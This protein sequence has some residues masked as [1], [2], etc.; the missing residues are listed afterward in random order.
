[1]TEIAKLAESLSPTPARLLR[2]LASRPGQAVSRY[3]ILDG[4][5]LPEGVST[6]RDSTRVVDV[7]V[8]A[9]RRYLAPTG[10]KI[11]SVRGIG[12]RL[13]DGQSHGRTRDRGC[14]TTLEI[15]RLLLRG[16]SGEVPVTRLDSR[17]LRL[18]GEAKH[19]VH[20]PDLWRRAAQDKFVAR[21]CLRTHL[22]TLRQKLREVGSEI[23]IVCR[24]ARY[25]RLRRPLPASQ[26]SR[27]T[28]IVEERWGP[29]L[30]LDYTNDAPPPRRLRAQRAPKRN[31]VTIHAEPMCMFDLAAG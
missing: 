5:P 30:V 24:R 25:Y 2:L 7:H 21:A 8:Q 11:E 1:M 15:D 10:A 20:Q 29:P 9:L 17:M 27:P 23:E 19:E 6:L 4:W 22:A 28:A 18:L 26:A 12:Y 14:G 13:E 3:D 16:P 31:S